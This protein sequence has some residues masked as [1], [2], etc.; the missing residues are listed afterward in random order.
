[1]TATADIRRGPLAIGLRWAGEGLRRAPPVMT[2]A[3]YLFLFLPIAVLIV[4]SFNAANSTV[5]WTGFS[6]EWYAE[7]LDDRR[8]GRSL[9][10]SLII[11]GASAVASTCIGT[12]AALA[13]VK[14]RFP[15][16]D[17]LST[18]LVSPLILPE[19]V[20]GV[21]LLVFMV[22]LGFPLGYGSLIIGHTLVS[23][24]FTTLIVRA[25]AASLDRALEEAGA[26]LGANPRQVFLRITLPILMPAILT[27][28]LLAATLSFDNFVMSTF[29]T[30]VGTTPLPLRIY[31]TLRQG[32]SPEINALGTLM[33]LA[34]VGVILLVMGRY[35]RFIKGG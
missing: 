17:L 20:I 33:V 6:L 30:G 16:R 1:M 23:V 5:H 9:M 18:A 4:F 3:A 28:F 32:I 8:I 34:N 31:S 12:L 19:I 24:P 21:G 13:I 26:D 10:I 11:A 2:A 29:V 35:L 14:R 27:G 25:A 15:G 7:V 22:S